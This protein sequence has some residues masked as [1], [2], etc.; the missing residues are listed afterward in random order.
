MQNNRRRL[1][2]SIEDCLMKSLL[3]IF[4]N[5][6]QLVVNKLMAKVV[7]VESGKWKMENLSN[8]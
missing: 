1:D 3:S 6:K 2:S 8:F 4:L 5:Q 7:K